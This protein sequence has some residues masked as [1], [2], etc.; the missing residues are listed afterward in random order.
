MVCVLVSL[1]ALVGCSALV[2]KDYGVERKEIAGTFAKDAL[3]H[4]LFIL[5]NKIYLTGQ[6]LFEKKN[7]GAG[8]AAFDENAKL[9][10]I[11]LGGAPI[12]SIEVFREGGELRYELKGV[13][14]HVYVNNVEKYV[15]PA[16]PVIDDRKWYR[17]PDTALV[18]LVALALD[19]IY[20]LAF[21]SGAHP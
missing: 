2:L 15:I 6:Y 1:M 13:E 3:A 7:L 12:G 11:K 18:F 10:D 14:Y 4:R 8:V 5:D 19:T 9:I 17:Y 16:N 20:V 21:F